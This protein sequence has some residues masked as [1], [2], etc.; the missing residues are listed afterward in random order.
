MLKN[1]LLECM[2]ICE[3]IFKDTFSSKLSFLQ[4]RKMPVF[5]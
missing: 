1:T 4:P 5:P 2:D 3:I